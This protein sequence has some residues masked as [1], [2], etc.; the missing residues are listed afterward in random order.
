MEPN[1][2]TE[3]KKWKWYSCPVI[4][5]VLLLTLAP[6]GIYLMWRYRGDGSGQ[7][8]AMQ[9]ALT[10]IFGWLFYQNIS[11]ILS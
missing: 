11:I 9:I 6:L 7:S 8:I 1:K 10:I 5:T 4:I 3:P 2:P